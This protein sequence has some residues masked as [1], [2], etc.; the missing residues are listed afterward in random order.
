M[1]KKTG[2][3][4]LIPR[5]EALGAWSMSAPKTWRQGATFGALKA[6][7]RASPGLSPIG[8]NFS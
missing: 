7:P 6:R 4:P 5:L 2:S 1:A 8:A 3:G